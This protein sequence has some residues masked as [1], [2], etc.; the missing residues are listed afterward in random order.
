MEKIFIIGCGAAGLTEA[1]RKAAYEKV[2]TEDVILVDVDNTPAE[3][4]K[5][6]GM[7]TKPNTSPFEPA[8]IPFRKNPYVEPLINTFSNR[9]DNDRP[10]KQ[11]FHKRSKKHR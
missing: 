8:P 2:G 7:P 1:I 4:L 6:L 11:R 3:K 9:L 5:E 10:W